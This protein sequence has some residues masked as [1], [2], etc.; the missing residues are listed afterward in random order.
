M[1]IEM[2]Y[3]DVTSVTCTRRRLFCNQSGYSPWVEIDF[4]VVLIAPRSI[5]Y[6][7]LFR[8]RIY[9]TDRQDERAS[10]RE[11]ARESESEREKR[12]GA[13]PLVNHRV[14]ACVYSCT[15][16]RDSPA[17]LIFFLPSSV[18][19]RVL[20]VCTARA[21]ETKTEMKGKKERRITWPEAGRLSLL[22]LL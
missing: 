11:R 6:S 13:S 14:T 21:R 8:T 22:F 5:E 2:R 3:S 17:S 18:R 1:C 4:A 16:S 15:G 12:A 9:R 7:P 19:V 20:C 10:E